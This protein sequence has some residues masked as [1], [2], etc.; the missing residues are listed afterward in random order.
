M[1]I[2]RS[3]T[4]VSEH[5]T[6]AVAG[7][8]LTVRVRRHHASRRFRLRYDA[9]AGELRL[10][11]PI[12][13]RIGPARDWVAAQGV[14][15]ARQMADRPSGGTIVAPG[16]L[17]PWRGDSLHIEWQRALPRGPRIEGNRLL[18]GGELPSVGPRVRR[19]VQAQARA[20]FGERTRAMA[21]AEGLPLTSVSIGDPRSRWGSCSG[22]GAIRYNWRLALAP[23]DVRHAIVAHEVAHLAHMNHGPHFHALADRLG[24]AANARS[25]AWLKANGAMLHALRFDPD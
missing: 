20:E 12:R 22:S 23:D 10:T 24:G 4:P 7:A 21:I 19:W 5:F 1:S 15:I 25:K 8:V 16:S 11:L 3:E 17:L 9:V 2:A 18:V 14:W 13:R 6:V